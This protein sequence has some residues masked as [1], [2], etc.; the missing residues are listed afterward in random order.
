[1][2]Q[3]QLS[4]RK[5]EK[6]TIDSSIEVFDTLI[7]LLDTQVERKPQH[8]AY[9]FLENGEVEASTLTFYQLQQR[10]KAIAAVLQA[11]LTQGDRVLLLYPPGLDFI[12]AF[13]G[14][15]YA[16]VIAVPAYPPRRNQNLDRLQSIVSDCQATLALTTSSLLPNLEKSFQQDSQFTSL[17]LLATD[18]IGDE[19]IDNWFCPNITSRTI[20]FLQYTSG[21][22]GNPKGVMVS[23]RNLTYNQ[24]TIKAGFGH[25]D[26]TIFVG[27]LPLFHDMGLIGNVLQPLYLGIHCI[28]MAPVSFLQK[29]LR[30]LQAISRYGGTT[31]G[32]PNFAY[33]LCVNKITDEQ[34]A[35][36]NLSHWEVAFNGAEPI[37]SKSLVRFAEAFAPCG[38][39]LEAFYPCYGMAEATLFVSG[40]PKNQAPTINVFGEKSNGL[41]PVQSLSSGE[42]ETKNIVGVGHGWLDQKIR[43]VDPDSLKTCAIGQEGEIWLAG[44]SVA[45]GYWNNREKTE[46]TFHAHIADTGEGPFLRTGDLGFFGENNE[47]FVTGRIKDMIIIRGR[48]HYP[49]DIESTVEKSHKALIPNHSAA[50]CVEVDGEEQLIITAEIERRY[51]HR[52]Q[53]SETEKQFQERRKNIQDRRKEDV[54]P[55]FSID[56]D[57]PPIFNEIALEV[58]KN[59]SKNHGLQ[60]YAL[61]FLRFGSIPKTSSG[62]IQR[63]A[64]RNGFITDNLN[65]VWR[66]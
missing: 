53:S 55:G 13:F 58:R 3:N 26:K 54:N 17:K 4:F 41:T 36:L 34:K 37:R 1:M 63:Y 45:Q 14:C 44:Q 24:Q 2:L 22:T 25:T 20:A 16:G 11:Q 51:R 38:F 52:R 19:L 65:V 15:L 59:V 10:A 32:G 12:E 23:Q 62:K 6:R 66:I 56:L 50:F 28:L 33:D 57:S 8:K 21:S 42:T 7:H 49:Q 61:W 46:E 27:W 30:W 39:R 5:M 29:P 47:L 18:N 9:T 60:V 64:C 48:N 43:I 40:N 31:S 35:E